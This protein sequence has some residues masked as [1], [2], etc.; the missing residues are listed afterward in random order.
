[1]IPVT[2]ERE[3]ARIVFGWMQQ[4]IPNWKP[5]AQ[6]EELQELLGVRS[7]LPVEVYDLGPHH[8]FLEL[9]SEEE[10]AAL[11]PDFGA[12]GR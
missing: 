3:G 9:G 5:F 7:Q 2:L 12:L 10:V 11:E 1:M 4:P 6:A 8:V